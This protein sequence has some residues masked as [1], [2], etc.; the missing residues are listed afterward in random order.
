MFQLLVPKPQARAVVFMGSP[1]DMSHCEK[2]RTNCQ[3]LGMPCELRVSSAHKATEETMKILAEY[4][5]GV[6]ELIYL[7]KCFVP[8]SEKK[9]KK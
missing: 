2:I 9:K 3:Q 6:S 4:E 7:E 5:G 8:N 1:T